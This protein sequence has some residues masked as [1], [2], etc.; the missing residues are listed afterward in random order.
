M[1]AIRQFKSD[2]IPRQALKDILLA[3]TQAP[4]GGN[5]QPWHFVVVEDQKKKTEFAK[6]YRE[7]WWSK[8]GDMGIEKPE[9]IAK[10]DK[11]SQSAMKL[12]DN[13]AEAPV[14]VLVCATVKFPQAET[15]VIPATQNLLL[16]ARAL[17]IGG[18]ITTL[19]V[20]V[21][22]SLHQL[23]GIPETAQVVYCVPLGYPKGSFGPLDRKPLEAVV[24]E[25][26]WGQLPDWL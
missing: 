4:S 5:M 7:A 23:F 12:A 15:F 1:R 6:L 9:Q 18:T 24:S 13:I 14:I 17:G 20:N 2:V 19:H 26:S 21:E 3:A 10:E 8:R 22:A 11:V 25:D 16:A